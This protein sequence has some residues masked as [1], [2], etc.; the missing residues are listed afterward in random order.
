LIILL[1]ARTACCNCLDI[2]TLIL[3]IH[4]ELTENWVFES[5]AADAELK[6]IDFGLSR[7]FSAD[8]VMHVPVGTP[9]SIAPEVLNGSYTSACDLWSLGMSVSTAV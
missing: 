2:V 1:A 4:T 3:C 6:L 8:E 9:Y 5:T 7:H